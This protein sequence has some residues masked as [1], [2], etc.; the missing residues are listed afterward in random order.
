MPHLH[1]KERL[2]VLEKTGGA[3]FHGGLSIY[4]PCLRQEQTCG[5]LGHRLRVQSAG[6]KV[7]PVYP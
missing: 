6:Q 1:L 7:Y 3:S 4:T 2:E 5:C